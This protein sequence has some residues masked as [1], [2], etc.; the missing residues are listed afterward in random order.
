MKKTVGDNNEID[1]EK[2]TALLAQY[3]IEM[4]ANPQSKAVLI[5]QTDTPT[6]EDF[7]G[8]IKMGT[9]GITLATKNLNEAPPI[10]NSEDA[11]FAAGQNPSS[12]LD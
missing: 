8:L 4:P 3:S 6:D 12:E 5:P 11:E 7:L 9:P 1:T 2:I 10:I